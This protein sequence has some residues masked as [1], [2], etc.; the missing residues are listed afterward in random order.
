MSDKVTDKV[1]EKV[2][3]KVAGRFRTE[4]D[5]NRALAPYFPTS[6]GREEAPAVASFGDSDF[7]NLKTCSNCAQNSIQETQNIRGPKNY[8]LHRSLEGIHCR[9]EV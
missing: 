1:I 3:D 8:W 7:P 2:K 6:I 9:T 5:F 4:K